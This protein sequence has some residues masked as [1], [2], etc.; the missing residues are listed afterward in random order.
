VV[1][2]L[3]NNDESNIR[4]RSEKDIARATGQL[5]GTENRE[6]T[7]PGNGPLDREGSY[8]TRAHIDDDE[9]EEE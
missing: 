9:D 2:N 4:N 3:S 7:D 5:E 8:I 1:E 6:N